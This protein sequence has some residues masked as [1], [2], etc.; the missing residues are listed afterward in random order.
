MPNPAWLNRP[1]DDLRV[2]NVVIDDPS[3]QR[4]PFTVLT[5][6]GPVHA[7]AM[8]EHSSGAL[9]VKSQQ[10]PWPFICPD[11]KEI[12]A[13]VSLT[14]NAS[15]FENERARVT[16]EQVSARLEGF[17]FENFQLVVI[18]LWASVED[19]L[20]Q[21]FDWASPRF[22]EAAVNG[23]VS[24]PYVS[25][26]LSVDKSAPMADLRYIYRELLHLV[27]EGETALPGEIHAQVQTLLDGEAVGVR[28]KAVPSEAGTSLQVDREDLARQAKHFSRPL[29]D[30]EIDVVAEHPL[31]A[32]RLLFLKKYAENTAAAARESDAS[33][34]EDAYRHVLWSFHLTREYGPTFAEQVTDA[35][36]VTPASLISPMR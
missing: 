21:D 9:C 2:Y 35:H 18:G 10:I 16:V 36:E 27:R 8:A 15:G 3:G 19:E 28:L 5:S 11:V 26:D 12:E 22:K 24:A 33:V 20:S 31:R 29:T 25:F 14:N 32:P 17:S 6:R 4:I 7:K 30:A 34:P 13:V 23:L 1:E